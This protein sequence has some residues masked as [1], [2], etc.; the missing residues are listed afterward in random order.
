MKQEKTFNDEKQ[1]LTVINFQHYQQ[2][3]VH[4]HLV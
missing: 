1:I 4:Y 3:K 2:F